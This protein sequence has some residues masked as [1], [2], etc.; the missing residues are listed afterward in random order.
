MQTL[1]TLAMILTVIRPAVVMVVMIAVVIM[2]VVVMVAMMNM[3]WLIVRMYVDQGA[4]ECAHGR[5]K[6]HAH[7]RRDGKHERHRPD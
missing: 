7:T 2:V 3:A 5:S 4:R 6:G 1:L